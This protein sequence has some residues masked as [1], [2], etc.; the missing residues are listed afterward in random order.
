MVLTKTVHFRGNYVCV[1]CG[2]KADYAAAPARITAARCNCAGAKDLHEMHSE[3]ANAKELYEESIQ[4]I[5]DK[6]SLTVRTNHALMESM[7]GDYRD[8]L[9]HD[10]T[11]D[12][13][14]EL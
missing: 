1:F 2:T 4:S 10:I 14:K 7:M 6:Y 9:L 13:D 11:E 3:M 5:H 8:N 12:I